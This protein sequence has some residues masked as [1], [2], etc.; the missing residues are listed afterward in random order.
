M[1]VNTKITGFTISEEFN[2]SQNCYWDNTGQNFLITTGTNDP[3]RVRFT[4]TVKFNI[5]ATGNTAT[6]VMRDFTNS[7]NYTDTTMTCAQQNQTGTFE[8][9]FSVIKSFNTNR[10]VGLYVTA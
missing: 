5:T 8:R 7:S 1:T 6:I 9:S 10:L 4:C 2:A 3:V